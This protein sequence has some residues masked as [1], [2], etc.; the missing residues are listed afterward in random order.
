MGSKVS[1]RQLIIVLALS[2]GPRRFRITRMIKILIEFRTVYCIVT[3]LAAETT[4]TTGEHIDLLNTSL[5]TQFNFY[6]P[7]TL[8]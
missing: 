5:N 1:S 2:S 8:L 6:A 7:T 3:G 4:A